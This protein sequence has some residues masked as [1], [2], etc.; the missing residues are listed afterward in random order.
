MAL[1]DLWTSSRDQLRQKHVQQ[2][3]AFAGDGKL[4]DGSDASLEFRDFLAQVPSALLV[5][6]ADECLLDSFQNSGYALQDIVNQVGRRLGFEV[7]DGRYRGTS[8]HVGFDGLWYFPTGHVVIVEVKTTD[9]YRLKLDKVVGYHR[10]L[11]KRGTLPVDTMH[12][13]LSKRVA[14]GKLLGEDQSPERR[15]LRWKKRPAERSIPQNGVC[16]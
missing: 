4:L 15:S 16:I 10:D 2:I 3:I 6:Y 14:S 13:D 9:V 1:V 12:V 11:V 8:A 5:R 7:I